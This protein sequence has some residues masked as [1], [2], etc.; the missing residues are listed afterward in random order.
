MESTCCGWRKAESVVLPAMNR[1][2]RRLLRFLRVVRDLPGSWLARRGARGLLRALVRAGGLRRAYG[3]LIDYTSLYPGEQARRYRRWID[4]TEAGSGGQPVRVVV[5]VSFR[6]LDDEQFGSIF[7]NLIETTPCARVFVDVDPERH[8]SLGELRAHG[9]DAHPMAG[10]C[11]LPADAL[12]VVLPGRACCLH[13]N[14]LA[15]ITR[16][17]DAGAD[18]VYGDSDQ[19]DAEGNRQLPYFKPDYS[20]DLLFHQ[21]Y[22]S[23]CVG[24]SCRIWDGTWRF[25]NPYASVL[26]SVEAASCVEHL[27]AILSHA[28]AGAVRTPPAPPDCL[29]PLLQR[30]YGSSARVEATPSGWRCRFG[31]GARA[32]VSVV[33]PTRDRIDLLAPCVDSLYATNAGSGFEIIVVDNGSREPETHEWLGRMERDRGDF[34]TLTADIEFNWSRL[35]NLAMADAAGDVFVFLNNDTVSMTDGWLARIAEY[36]SREDVGVVGALL[37]FG[38]GTIQHAGVVVGYGGRAG[39]VYSG[40]RP[41]DAS[42]AFVPPT[43]PRN[44]ATVTGACLAVSRNVVETIGVF[45]EDY[46][47]VGNDTEFCLRAHLAGLH[48]VYL[49]EIVLLH[50]ESQSRGRSDPQSDNER[51]ERFIA[52]HLPRDPYYNP[53]LTL[54][55]LHPGL[56]VEV[57]SGT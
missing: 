40:V 32:H 10:E 5:A 13:P 16:A 11:R 24:I 21:D 14:S 43:V 47:I 37:L 19:I 31:N 26:R 45:N 39:H 33:I 18:L 29:E 48:N 54:S 51:L 7:A 25:D 6:G 34:R 23:D 38:D 49:P 46:R 28:L 55:S 44:V 27:P 57:T 50:H 4:A 15:A 22:M 12:G 20:P 3:V 2:R 56:S 35:N 42:G 9:V 17:L 52:K 53:N 41:E 8:D 1:H 36:A 30:R